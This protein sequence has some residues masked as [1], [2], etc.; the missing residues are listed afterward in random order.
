VSTLQHLYQQSD[1]RAWLRKQGHEFSPHVSYRVHGQ[2]LLLS[3]IRHWII[4]PLFSDHNR[5]SFYQNWA[6]ESCGSSNHA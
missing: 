4:L 3:M 6:D 5:S 1:W 2:K